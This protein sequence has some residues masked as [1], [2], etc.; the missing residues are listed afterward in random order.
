MEENQVSNK[1]C[2]Q[3]GRT[4]NAEISGVAVAAIGISAGVI[5]I[6]AVACM[7]AGM[8]NSGDPINLLTS[9]IKA[10]IG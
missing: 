1:V 3:A 10:I 5:G 4:A 7:V 8:L 9:L 6:W 2:V